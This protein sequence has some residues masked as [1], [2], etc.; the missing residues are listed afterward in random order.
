MHLLISDQTKTNVSLVR[1]L[2]QEIH[3]SL[4]TGG[5]VDYSSKFMPMNCPDHQTSFNS[6]RAARKILETQ[7]VSLPSVNP[8]IRSKIISN[9]YFVFLEKLG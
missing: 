5:P 9:K 4:N 7:P 2:I 1:Y 6:S 8:F 3:K